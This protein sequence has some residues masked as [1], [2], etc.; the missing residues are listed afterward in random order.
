MTTS[1]HAN[2]AVIM[3]YI[4]RIDN[5]RLHSINLSNMT[6]EKNS[7]KKAVQ[8]T[9]GLSNAFNFM[10]RYFRKIINLH[11]TRAHNYTYYMLPEPRLNFS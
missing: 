4:N 5:A 2:S 8:N 10:F 6:E 1:R 9:G 7:I 11:L 3:F